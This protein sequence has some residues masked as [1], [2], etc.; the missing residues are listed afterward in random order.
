VIAS[1]LGWIIFGLIIGALARLLVPGTQSMGLLKT[2]LLGVT[3]SFVG[4]F[5]GFLLVGG[6]PLQ[7]AGWIGSLV[8]A[9]VVL[10][11]SGATATRAT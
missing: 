9:T 4:G 10:L 2:M 5:V 11:L 1:I 8:G 3:G 7:A 6:S